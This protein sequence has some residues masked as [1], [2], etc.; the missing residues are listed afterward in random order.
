M[1]SCSAS[2]MVCMVVR[3]KVNRVA[4]DKKLPRRLLLHNRAFIW[5][6]I[7]VL[8]V[9]FVVLII[10]VVEGIKIREAFVALSSITSI[11]VMLSTPWTMHVTIVTWN[12]QY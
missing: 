9:L 4:R 10:T 8:T 12:G 2:C 3:Y 6:A 5:Q 1:I 7:P 11:K